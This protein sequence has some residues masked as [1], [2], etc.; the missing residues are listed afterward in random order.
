MAADLYLYAIPDDPA[1]LDML[2]RMDAAE[3]E[4]AWEDY[5]EPESVVFGLHT[6]KPR[7]NVWIGEVSWAKAGP[8]GS[9][10]WQKW[11]PD[12]VWDIDRML[13]GNPVLTPQLAAK[14]MVA[15]NRPNRSWYGRG[16]TY[17][18][19]PVG[20]GACGIGTRRVRISKDHTREIIAVKHRGHNSR[21]DVKRWLHA[22]MGMRIV[23]RSE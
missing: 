19:V 3:A 5:Y 2:T 14:I 4:G 18:H 16:T 22:H 1:L 8:I 21:R 11:V 17:Q 13:D 9:D 6:D 20:T 12:M 10:D 23:A 7:D 15:M